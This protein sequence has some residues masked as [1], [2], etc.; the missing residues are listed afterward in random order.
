MS[1]DLQN[2]FQNDTEVKA[3]RAEY[4]ASSSNLELAKMRR[5]I[6]MLL[7][8]HE[9]VNTLGVDR[10]ALRILLD[11]VKHGDYNRL[12]LEVMGENNANR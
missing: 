5:N 1:S 6:A 4:N 12:Q 2:L 9:P 7:S 11:Y 8:Q 3:A 10:E